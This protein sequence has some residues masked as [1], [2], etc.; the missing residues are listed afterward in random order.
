MDLVNGH[1][2]V[3]RLELLAASQPVGVAAGVAGEIRDLG[4]RL[5]PDLGGEG[6]RVGLESVVATVAGGDG[7]FVE[8][9]GPDAGEEALPDARR[10]DRPQGARA[11]ALAF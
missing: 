6:I 9:A 4:G 7:V 10:G 11:F 2:G 1:G 5:W 3:Q 8:G